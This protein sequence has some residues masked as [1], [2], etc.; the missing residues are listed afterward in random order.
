LKLQK[1]KTMKLKRLIASGV[2]LFNFL[3][4]YGLDRT[5][6]GKLL[7]AIVDVLRENSHRYTFSVLT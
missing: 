6:F 1:G 5:S 4:C 3:D 2:S 7:D